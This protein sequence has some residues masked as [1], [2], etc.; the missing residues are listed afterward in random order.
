MG[1]VDDEDRG[2]SEARTH[3]RRSDGVVEGAPARNRPWAIILVVW[4][5]SASKEGN[6]GQA[7]GRRG[8]TGQ[9]VGHRAPAEDG[10]DEV[11]GEGVT[12]SARA[13]ADQREDRGL[14][15]NVIPRACGDHDGAPA[16]GS[17]DEPAAG[18]RRPLP[19]MALQRT[20]ARQL[21]VGGQRVSRPWYDRPSRWGGLRR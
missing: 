9:G 11:W 17:R 7:R 12:I 2:A 5:T 3:G 18:M 10:C 16:G 6:R 21:L 19:N 8:S 4:G 20:K 14:V 1:P 13:T 15:R